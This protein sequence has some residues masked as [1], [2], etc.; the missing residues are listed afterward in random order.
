MV[1]VYLILINYLFNY[2][3]MSLFTY[4]IR[5]WGV[6]TW[7]QALFIYLFI[8]IFFASLLRLAREGKNNACYIYLTSH[9][10]PPNLH[11]LTSPWHVMLLANQRLFTRRQSNFGQNNVSFEIN[12]RKRKIFKHVQIALPK[13]KIKWWNTASWSC[14]T[15]T[16]FC[17]ERSKKKIGWSTISKDEHLFFEGAFPT[18]FTLQWIHCFFVL[19]ENRLL[20]LFGFSVHTCL[21]H[22]QVKM[23]H[24]AMFCPSS[25][26]PKELRLR[27][28]VTPSRCIQ[29]QPC[30]PLVKQKSP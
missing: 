11:N 8:Y 12:F 18:K 10:P 6:V 29:S 25:T 22:F 26:S 9:Q 19:K 15:L 17:A 5:V 7:D 20:F 2:L 24:P 23:L 16:S 3:I 21:F 13:K 1:I 30:Q 4:C 14:R 27:N 28:R